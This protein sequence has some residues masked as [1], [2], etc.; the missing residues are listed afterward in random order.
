MEHTNHTGEKKN[1]LS[2]DQKHFIGS[3]L[4][5]VGVVF[6]VLSIMLLITLLMLIKFNFGILLEVIA[7]GDILTS[8]MIGLLATGIVSFGVGITMR[9]N[10]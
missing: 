2:K 5:G 10:K 3:V 7:S 8:M 1:I 9:G 6:F 4:S